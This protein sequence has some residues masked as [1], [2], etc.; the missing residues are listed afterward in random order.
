MPVLLVDP[1]GK[2]TTSFYG[3]LDEFITLVCICTHLLYT[4]HQ[5]LWI[6]STSCVGI[7]LQVRLHTAE[8]GLGTYLCYVISAC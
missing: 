3:S 1:A 7:S 5:L 4:S 6:C 2:I 8:Q